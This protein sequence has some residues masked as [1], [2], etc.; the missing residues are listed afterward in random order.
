MQLE[1]MGVEEVTVEAGTFQAWRIDTS[2]A[3]GNPDKGSL[4]VDRDTRRVVK[5]TAVL[6]Q[7]GGAVLTAEL[8]P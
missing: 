4:W 2:S 1:V 5:E 7:M 8:V 6:P 3:E